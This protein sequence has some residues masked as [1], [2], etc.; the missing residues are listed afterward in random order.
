MSRSDENVQR[1]QVRNEEIALP[2][3]LIRFLEERAAALEDDLVEPLPGEPPTETP[4]DA[5]KRAE[6]N[7]RILEKL[8]ILSEVEE[9]QKLDAK[10]SRPSGKG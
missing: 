8:G 10:R 6:I 4:K 3:A 1:G 5:E 9:L 2:P 7:R